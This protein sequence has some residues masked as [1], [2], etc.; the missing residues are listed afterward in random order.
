MIGLLRFIRGICAFVFGTQVAGL[1]PAL[2][3]LQD[4]DAIDGKMMASV[5]IK[6][7]ALVISALLFFGLRNSINKLHEKKHGTQHPLLVKRWVL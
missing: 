6:I 5:A 2:T 3:W 1:L 7:A 4:V